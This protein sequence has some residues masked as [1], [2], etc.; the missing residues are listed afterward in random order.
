VTEAA[1]PF[2]AE[3]PSEARGEEPPAP[4]SALADEPARVS[5]E[6]EDGRDEGRIASGHRDHAEAEAASTESHVETVAETPKKPERAPSPPEDDNRPKRGGWW[7][8]RSFF[9]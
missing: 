3:W 8:R 6:S 1:V 4:V 2:D 5:R 7:Q 9:G